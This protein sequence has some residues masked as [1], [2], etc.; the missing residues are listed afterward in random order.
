MN[1][2]ASGIIL[3]LLLL[4]CAILLRNVEAKPGQGPKKRI[5]VG[6]LVGASLLTLVL[7]LVSPL[8]HA[9]PQSIVAF[10]ER[11][12]PRHPNALRYPF[13]YHPTAQARNTE[14]AAR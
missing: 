12:V 6:I 2:F 8:A 4:G 5:L 1:A 7:T 9:V 3:A 14:S 10:V 13:R 11:V